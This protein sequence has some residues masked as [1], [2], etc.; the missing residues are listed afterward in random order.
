MP[1]NAFAP[2]GETVEPG[3]ANGAAVEPNETRVVAPIPEPE[4]SDDPD[5]FTHYVHL[6]DGRVLR[7]NLHGKHT[8]TLGTRFYEGEGDD[9]KSAGII[10]VYS[11]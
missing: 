6:A 5:E 4:I 7:A 2:V 8:D 3:K 10:G 1:D 11:R 9:E